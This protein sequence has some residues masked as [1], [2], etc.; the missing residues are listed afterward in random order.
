MADPAAALDEGGLRYRPFA[1]TAFNGGPLTL[2]W[3]EGY[4]C[5]YSP[6]WVCLLSPAENTPAFRVEAGERLFAES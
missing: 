3:M 4:S 2:S 5:A 6:R 1:I